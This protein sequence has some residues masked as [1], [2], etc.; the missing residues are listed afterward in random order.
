MIYAAHI[1]IGQEFLINKVLYRAVDKSNNI[2]KLTMPVYYT[3]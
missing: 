1:N 2:E 3:N